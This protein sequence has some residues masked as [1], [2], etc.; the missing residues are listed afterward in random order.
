L[1]PARQ[2]IPVQYLTRA[3]ADALR[4]D[5]NETVIFE[6]Q[7]RKLL[8]K[9]YDVKY[10]ELKARLF[11]PPSS[12]PVP[13]GARTFTYR[14]FDHVGFWNVIHG[15]ANDYPRANLKAREFTAVTRW[16]GNSFGW[17]KQD[18][19]EASFAGQDLAS[20]EARAARRI[21]EEAL[22]YIIAFG[23][24]NHNIPG[25]LNH[26]NVTAASVA[27]VTSNT[28]WAEKIADGDTESVI[29]DLLEQFNT[30]C[31]LTSE[32]E[33]PNALALP[34]S[35]L[36]QLQQT[37]RSEASEKK[38]IDEVRERLP[39]ITFIEDWY[40]LET[41]GSSSTKRMVMYVRDAEHLW[42]E[43]PQEVEAGDV[44]QTGHNA[45]EVPLSAKTGGVVIPY[46]LAISYRDGL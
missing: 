28:T 41:A 16:I 17:S 8:A 43:I 21:L 37:K 12:D 19:L 14:Q 40:R 46:P 5:A 35:S 2:E 10:S 45:F 44:L 1:T 42:R 7:L 29:A 25:F 13:K 3:V 31:S 11:V 33:K 34:P 20:D 23:L 32:V 15:Y 4:L 9:T 6:H 18:M 30:T 26:P 38:L 36:R 22:D 27:T 24:S 39:S